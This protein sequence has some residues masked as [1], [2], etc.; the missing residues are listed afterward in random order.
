MSKVSAEVL[1]IGG[2][3]A[4]LAAAVAASA[5][6]AVTIVDDNPHLGGQIWRAEMGKIKSPDAK[7]LIE[8][9]NSG[10]AKIITNAQVFGSDSHECLLAETPDGTFEMYYDRLILATGAR[11][12]FL[13]F[14][15]WALPN[16]LG[17][18]G[19]QAMVK[20][21]LN[22][23]NKRVVV[24]GTG[25]LL[26]AVADYLKAKG[27]T[28]VCIAEQA[29]ASKIRRLAFGLWR[30][31]SKL[32]QGSALR[33][34]LFGIPYLTDCWVTAA[35]GHG[36]LSQVSLFRKG[37]S[38]T[39]D[40][41]YLACGFHLVPNVELATVLGCKI[42]QGVVS[43]DEFQQ[44]TVRNI[45]CAGE[46]TGIGGVEASLIEGK[47][48]GLAASGQTDA[49]P[50]HFAACDKTRRF[51][52]ALNEAF[53]LRDELK[54]LAEPDT[55]VCRCEDVEYGRLAEFHN[56]RD[57]KLQTRCGM[58]PCQGRICGSANEFLFGWK[59]GTVR[60]PIFP[61]KMEDL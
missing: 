5:N 18:G 34:R 45:F 12:R 55:I 10:K 3:S 9:V 31:P 13:P 28:V 51:G 2:G 6:S 38:W 32:A 21:G 61:V 48:A 37:K 59:P 39:V 17:A 8:Q 57:A 50:S 42:E 22:I 44:T 30:Y 16:V 26:L 25:P 14:P 11:E 29:R 36:K 49:A 53:A 1:V 20:G 43:V 46:P 24:A 40:C 56:S 58:G 54:T 47:I 33:A 19:L 35:N 60:P 7:S 27:A 52:D 4:G 23:E 15:G 41:D